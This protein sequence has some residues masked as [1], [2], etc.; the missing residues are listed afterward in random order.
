MLSVYIG[1]DK[2]EPIAWDVCAYTL[3]KYASQ[4]VFYQPLKIDKLREQGLC[5]RKVT[6][7][8]GQMFDVISQAPQSTEFAI[9]RFLVPLIHQEGWAIFMD[10]DMV[11]MRDIYDI[12]PYLDDSKAVMCVKH[13][14]WPSEDTKMDNQIQTH[15]QRKNWSSFVAFNCSHPA[16]QRL[17][18]KDV[19]SIPG[20][21]L[22]AFAWLEDD[23]IGELPADWNWLV[24]V[25]DMPDNPAVAH[26]TLGGPWFKDW[27]AQQYDDLWLAELEEFLHGRQ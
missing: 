6:T 21:E 27:Q 13:K 22:H 5:D 2:R 14:H 16:N 18:L 26:F 7:K 10:C 25:Q 17:T 20:R 15:Y 19:N 9:S 23:E 11:F 24:N 1:Y 12:M 4:P 8:A 3:G